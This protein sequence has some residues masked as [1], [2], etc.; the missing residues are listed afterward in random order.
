MSAVMFA[1]ALV[2]FVIVIRARSQNSRAEL[3]GYSFAVVATDSMY[4]QI[5]AGDLIIVKSCSITEIKEGQNAVFIGLSGEFKDKSIV[6][7][8]VE[9]CHVTDEFGAKTGIALKTWG[10]NNGSAENPLYDEDLVYSSNF[11][12]REVFHS[13][14]LGAIVT[15]LQNPINWIYL[16]VF[17]LA[18][19]FAVSQGVKI[20]R[21]AKNKGKNKSTGEESAEE[22]K[23]EEVVACG[24]QPDK[25]HKAEAVEEP[26]EKPNN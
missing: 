14:T 2:V 12:G 9:I 25:E 19:S 1:F 13:A 22:G 23:Q 4:P 6:H 16:L 18:I 15:F 17:V 21:L 5:R 8:V 11:I 26:Q 7:R 10:I 24:E 20:V 3:F